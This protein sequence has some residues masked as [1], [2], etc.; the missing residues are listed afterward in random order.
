MEPWE[1]VWS[2]GVRENWG[3]PWSLTSRDCKACSASGLR[4]LSVRGQ[5]QGQGS[6]QSHSL[7]SQ[8]EDRSTNGIRSAHLVDRANRVIC[9]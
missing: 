7:V 4:G 8:T 1:T 3:T 6:Q 9:H 5:T 2:V